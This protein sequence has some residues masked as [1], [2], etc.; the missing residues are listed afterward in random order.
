MAAVGTVNITLVLRLLTWNLNLGRPDF[1]FS[2]LFITLCCF[3]VDESK[4]KIIS[5]VM[6]SEMMNVK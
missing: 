6:E 4:F 2:I 1:K 5:K 3:S